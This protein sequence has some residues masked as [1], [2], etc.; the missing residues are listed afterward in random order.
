MKTLGNLKPSRG[1]NVK[2][3]RLGRGIGSGLGKTAGKGH[4]GQ[5]ARKSGGIAAGF[6]GGQTPMYRRLPKRGFTNVFRT[7]YEIVN[8]GSLAKFAAG[9][10]VTATE[11]HAAGLIQNPRSK[12]KLLGKGEIKGALN[13]AV[14]GSSATAK[15][16]VE[17]AGGKLEIIKV[18]K[19]APAPKQKAK[20]SKK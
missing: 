15:A 6:E 13:I 4:K 11:L 5:R 17:K 10:K 19:A 2:N 16:A 1:S 9:S 14:H 12:V 18:E 3:K 20:T 7:E 8:L